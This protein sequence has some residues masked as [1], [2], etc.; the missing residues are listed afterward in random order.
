MRAYSVGSDEG[1]KDTSGMLI[2]VD[3]LLPARIYNIPVTVNGVV[4]KKIQ[5]LNVLKADSL[6]LNK[7][8]EIVKAK[9]KGARAPLEVYFPN[10]PAGTT[11]PILDTFFNQSRLNKD[12]DTTATNLIRDNHT[13]LS[14]LIAISVEINSSSTAT[15]N[16]LDAAIADAQA[17]KVATDDVATK[18]TLVEEELT[19]LRS[20]LGAVPGPGSWDKWVHLVRSQFE[21]NVQFTAE[22]TELDDIKTLWQAIS[23]AAGYDAATTFNALSEPTWQQSLDLF[24]DAD[25]QG[26][27]TAYKLARE[28]A[29][30]FENYNDAKYLDY[31][32]AHRNILKFETAKLYL[33]GSFN[34]EDF[35]DDFKDNIAEL[36]TVLGLL[37]SVKL[38]SQY[39]AQLVSLTADKQQLDASVSHNAAVVSF[40]QDRLAEANAAKT[41]LIADGSQLRN[42][43]T[44]SFNYFFSLSINIDLYNILGEAVF[45]NDARYITSLNAI[46]SATSD[47][48]EAKTQ[49]VQSQNDQT[50]LTGIIGDIS[51]RQGA[52][53]AVLD[54]GNVNLDSLNQTLDQQYKFLRNLSRVAISVLSETRDN[55]AQDFEDTSSLVAEVLTYVNDYSVT[56]VA[57]RAADSDTG[58]YASAEFEPGL[59][60]NSVVATTK[61]WDSFE[62]LSLTGLNDAGI[63]AAHDSIENFTVYL[64]DGID[65]V[66]INDSLGQ[67]YSLVSVYTGEGDDNIT[68]SNEDPKDDLSTYPLS[69]DDYPGNVLV[70]G[71]SGNNQLLIDDKGDPSGDT[72]VQQYA[73]GD[74]AGYIQLTGMAGQVIEDIYYP[75][76][77][78][79]YRAN[80]GDF[81]NGL[82]IITSVGDD[83][84][85]IRAL[86]GADHT[87]LS[88]RAGDDTITVESFIV[89]SEASLTIYGQIND[90]EFGAEA[91]VVSSLD[92]VAD[93]DIIDASASPIAV[94][95]YGQNGNDTIYGSEFDDLLHG[96]DNND[97][98]IG[99]LGED[100]IIASTGDDLVIG[101]HG[102]AL[103]AN[104]D[105]WTQRDAIAELA[106]LSSIIDGGSIDTIYAGD[107]NNTVIGGSAAD[108]ITSTTGNDIIIGDNGAIDYTASVLIETTDLDDSTG[109]ID[110]IDAGEGNNVILGGAAGDAIDTG[111]G[112]DIVLGDHGEVYFI[113]DVLRRVTSTVTSEGGVDVITL[114]GGNNVVIGGQAG[115][116]ISTDK[117]MDI[118]IGDS[119]EITYSVL[120]AIEVVMTTDHAYGGNDTINASSGNNIV[121]GGFG[122]DSITTTAGSDI[123]LGDDG[124]INYISADGNT[125]DIDL[126]LSLSTTDGGGADDIDSGSGDDIVIGGRFG[127]TIDTVDGNNLIIGDSGS[128]TAADDN[129]SRF[130]SLPIT[131]GLV[132]TIA[133]GDGG[134]DKITTGSGN[135]IVFGG[136]NDG[137]LSDS[138]DGSV[139]EVINV[140]EGNNIVLG[141]D[142]AI[143][144]VR[145]EREPG[146]PG[147][148]LDASDIDLIVSLSTTAG[149]GIDDIDSG[150]GDDI[151]IGGRFGD[152]IDTVDGNNLIIG[153]SG[154]ITAASSGAT[155]FSDQP[156]TIGR[157]ETTAFGDG[158]ADTINATAGNDIVLGGHLGDTIKVGEGNNIVLGDDGAIDYV[159]AEREP[160]VPGADLDASDIDLIASLS[161]TDGGGIDDIDSG[162]GDDILI[163]GR[164]GDTIDT[165]GGNNLIIGDSGIITAA[166]DNNS[167]F[168][169]LPL[170]IGRMETTAF[171]DGGADTIN[172]TAGNDIVL[173][174]HLGDTIKV[175]EGNNIVLG[176][177]GAIDYVRAEREP[178]VPG[179]DLDASDIDLIVSLSTTAG[180]GADDID[181]GSGDDILIGGRDDDFIDTLGGNNL[182]IGDSGIITAASSGATNFSDQPITIGRM[183]T[184]AF[185]DG[186]ADTI[187][188][189]AGNDIVLGGHLG[190]TIKV[191]EGNNI[192]LGD[193]GAIDYVRAER[194]PGVPGAD[195][196]ASDIDLIVS[197]STT[198]GGGADDI[199]SG[200]GDDILIGGRFGDTIDTVDGN[201]LIIGDS[202][203][204]TAADDNGSRF[205]SLLLTIGR[206]ETIAF[207]EG[208][209]DTINATT[210]ND[211]VLGGHLGDTIKV[212][213]GNNIV[214]G[215]DG[216]IDYAREER[217]PGVPGADLDA[218]DIDLI[219]SLSTTAGGGADDID[220][221][222]GDD[223]LIGGRDDDFIDTLGGN[224]LVIGDSGMITA[225]NEDATNFS[226]QPITIGRMETTAFGDGGAD[227]IN[228]TAGNDIVLGGHLGDTIKVGEGNNIVLG[229][230]GAIDYVRAEREPGVPG[231]DLDASD[232]D[233]IVSLS[234]TAGGG[235]DDIDS[236][237]GDDIL[238]GG[239]FGDTI[240][241]VDGNNLIIGDS[242]MITAAD[243]NGSRF[244]SLLLTIGRMET[245]AFGEGGADTINAT[246]GNDIV[247]G[248]HLGDTIK[249]G[250]GNNI[251]LGDDGAIDYVREERDGDVPGADADAS[252]IDLIVSLSTTAGGGADDIDSGSG[253]DILIGGR[254]DDFI[255]TLGGNNLVIG[256]SGM[257][258]AANEDATNF[259]DQPITIGRIETTEFGEGGSDK[260]TT[261][262]GNDIVFGGHND[263]S[264]SDSADGSVVEVIKVGEGNN[265]VLGDDGAI[266]YVR[267][268]R[269]PGVP[270]ADL[271][272]SDIDLIVSLS[273][274]AGGGA[275]DIDS[276]SGD[277]ILIG[278]RDD[279][280]IDTLG[281]NNLVIGDSGMITAANED[282]TN[283]SG[284]PITIGRMETTAFGDGGADTIN[285][286]TGND[287]VLGGHLGDTIKVGEGNNI[288][289]GD[290]GAID[291]AREERE[292][293]V[294]GADLDASDIDLIESLSTTAGGGADDID[295]GSG[296][297]IL[298]GGRDDDFIDTLGG[299]NLVIGD[300]GMITAANEDAT[301]FSG[302]PITIGRMETTAFG[303]GGADTINAAAGN[304]IVLGGYLGDTIKVGE[305][306][307]I[308]LGDDGA[309]DYV[310]EER[311]GDVPGADADASDI[312][313]IVS[314]STTAGG[315]ADDIDSGS[316]DDIL[317]GGRFGDT[318]DTVDGNNLIIGDSGSI[319]AADDNGSRFASLLLT[320]GRMET[321]AFGEGG[322]D[323]INATTGNDIVLGG[324]L[325]DT[326]K[327]GE[328]NNIVLGDD[329]AI[330][331]VREERDG[332]LP[333]ADT[334][335]SDI[336]LI[337]SLSTTE[338]GGVDDIDSGSGDDILIG[339][340]FGDTI[341]SLGG[342]N[343]VIG[344]SGIITAANRG[345]I[346]LQR[347]TD[348]NRSHRNHRVWR[349][350]RGYDQHWRHLRWQ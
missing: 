141:D 122:G 85:N 304:D 325:G 124:V 53:Q 292:P 241:T 202:G 162:S 103:K 299:N 75:R 288:V 110:T 328:G 113:D 320:I 121:L 7:E 213:E 172:A 137:S 203:M 107:G 61:A 185:G 184:T 186:G 231:A 261:G 9:L 257:I 62:V 272:A 67:A 39:E 248:G 349:R 41:A 190:D 258:T 176:D 206:M 271:D 221:G 228:A 145:A 286:T 40:F 279:D 168:A 322:A 276:G 209:A 199:D 99:N 47:L 52:V 173:G 54:T 15:L 55:A 64:G 250:E 73:D 71:G 70:D 329:G 253:D 142:G 301:N 140:G 348:H 44:I 93:D 240:D 266:D 87:V 6:S 22:T 105:T 319:T 307:N 38:K 11:N 340:R 273:T 179:A 97:L 148:D 323:T 153:D 112:N 331:Y 166:T 188:A 345:R 264:L 302:Q 262:S 220:S 95:I 187:N 27:V 149:G 268:E 214:L 226:G 169:D 297:D 51:Q 282:A 146:V 37:E 16:A 267:A 65:T 167:R 131:L 318:I 119:G 197:L 18:V 102:L 111:S 270:G 161:T 118:V 285:A 341:D 222:S 66:A 72:I 237:S 156:I 35:K 181:S 245:I 104:A 20:V 210:G 335:A 88:T 158:G 96:G 49:S 108:S 205:A 19:N 94:T 218:S 10:G 350:W 238:I 251:V 1:Y 196:D 151:L 150:S 29:K 260:I 34:F 23:N 296:D 269:E 154:I 294:P 346:E 127:D 247:L 239:R 48:L 216:A 174:G 43:Y 155:N 242:G 317:I 281:G 69:V 259:S 170:T 336:D 132:E 80:G 303:D 344:D 33:D 58:L 195:L 32:A 308:V 76:G 31:R 191:G 298:I 229:D 223:I 28:L 4:A 74:F 144:Y 68:L 306:N 280:F 252:D 77:D 30:D 89:D 284:Q 3:I 274:T 192:V 263:G 314:L 243:D 63:H 13:L 275:D 333:G 200:S 227:T 125:D 8:L 313:L 42:D 109:D 84:V 283:F 45:S 60:G 78:I 256:D 347:S 21:V 225:A 164:F 81:S 332:D 178:G 2:P 175:G 193:D 343:L 293:G 233:L 116:M 300:S 5:Q 232:I 224:N 120:G 254:D 133:F 235:A 152:T 183:E 287:I 217:E 326:I 194:E 117:G 315:G 198:A 92:S 79:Y 129:G 277:D 342:N 278:G 289:L 157:M 128:I 310:R 246:T 100:T 12:P 123:V 115:D 136:H 236:G 59:S 101:D 57:G 24:N 290:D 305:G 139:V 17:L 26:V 159:R 338:F 14:A 182:V 160:G 249:V 244:A 204:I 230:D 82:E 324:H 163:G 215:D 265:I 50:A 212:G 130:A 208:G 309:I 90:P 56:S 327:V 165:L 312:D 234:T 337:A 46:A 201:N 180:G 189:T 330:D 147:A 316:G 339:G 91:P 138:A 255:D 219:V 291:Y 36:N 86:H 295:S 321:I 114:T 171:G 98:I 135:D 143:D 25:F 126:I 134:S 211:I 207:G 311:D 83:Q 177:D 106:E 334:D